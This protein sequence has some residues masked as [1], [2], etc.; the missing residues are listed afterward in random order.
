MALHVH[1]LGKFCIASEAG[2]IPGLESHKIRELLSYLL[3]H[4]DRPQ[5]R[6]LL[7]SELWA[8][9]TSDKSL[10]YLR[11]G[12]WQLQ[13][14]LDPWLPSL[15][16]VESDWIQLNSQPDL[17]LDVDVFEQA[18]KAV[19][20]RSGIEL[21]RDQARA[22]SEA[23]QLYRNDL[24]VTWTEDW[25]LLERERLQNLY[26]NALDKLMDY[27][28]VHLEL[29]AG[30]AYGQLSL[31]CDEA[32]ECSHQRLMRLFALSGN[33]TA[34]LRQYQRCT[35]IL[36]ETFGVQPSRT[37]ETLLNAVRE[38]QLEKLMPGVPSGA[39]IPDIGVDVLTELNRIQV[40]LA[41]VQQSLGRNLLGAQDSNESLRA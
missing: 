37:T 32:R 40:M 7:A 15:F 24:L 22:L 26:L 1:L 25:C 19:Q 41:E 9:V 28:L 2:P 33:R 5:A 14:A 38:D 20:G 10:K 36:G 11:Q 16:S 31:A 8:D 23:V 29:E 35:A 30:L 18:L 12:L 34:A 17:M 3:L 6:T 27:S 13:V 4:L 39:L 21:H